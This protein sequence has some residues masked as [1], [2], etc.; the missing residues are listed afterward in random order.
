MEVTVVAMEHKYMK[1]EIDLMMDKTRIDGC[2]YLQDYEVSQSKGNKPFIKG[3]LYGRGNINFKCWSSSKAFASLQ[4]MHLKGQVVHITGEVSVFNDS[5][6]LVIDTAIPSVSGYSYLD[7]LEVIYD[8]QQ[9]WDVLMKVL[10]SQCTPDGLKVFQLI[11][12]D[13]RVQSFRTEFAAVTHHD[14]CRSGLLAHTTKVVHHLANIIEWYPEILRR[15]DKDTLLIGA[16]LHDIG[17]CMEYYH[18]TMSE[19]GLYISHL[20]SGGL[21]LASYELQIRQLK[22]DEFYYTMLAVTNQ[23]HGI[24]SERPRVLAAYLIHLVDGLDATMTDI[25]TQMRSN[26]STGVDAPVSVRDVGK[27]RY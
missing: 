23:H 8:E 12:Q 1:S 22:G 9:C 24:Y 14:S 20:L 11:M 7:F 26:S 17:K 10:S 2:L 27:L 5:K 19:Q 13:S 15:V 25:E 3:I 6:T 21:I 18:G 4:A 16:A